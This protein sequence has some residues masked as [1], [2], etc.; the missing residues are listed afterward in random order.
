MTNA[1]D[2]KEVEFTYAGASQA[3]VNLT[4]LLIEKGERVFLYGPSGSGKTTLLELLAGVLKAD[5]GQVQVLG[6][7]LT[8]STPAQRDAFRAA[9]IGY[10]FQS[11]NLIPYLDVAGNIALP[12]HLSAERRA[13][14]G[15][16]NLQEKMLSLCR[17][18]GIEGLMNRK[19][20]QLSVGQQ[21]RV[22]VARALLGNPGLILADE[23]TSSL[24]FDHREK[25]INLLFQVCDRHGTTVLFVS[26]DRTLERLFTRSLSFTDLNHNR[27]SVN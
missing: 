2:L 18:L 26:H 14:L 11:F 5:K 4:S 17:E 27:K 8:D 15:E 10:I 19:V 7:D 21:Q 6:V 12:L 20:T 9:Q 22:A 25:F 23:P 1:I 16:D 13:R 24:D 3:T